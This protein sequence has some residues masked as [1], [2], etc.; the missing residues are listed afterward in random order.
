MRRY[1][2]RCVYV[3]T[4]IALLAP[5]RR[6][7]DRG[8]CAANTP[9][10][11]SH[12]ACARVCVCV[13]GCA[14]APGAAP[15]L[16]RCCSGRCAEAG[17]PRLSIYMLRPSAESTA[18][19]CIDPFNGHCMLACSKFINSWQPSIRELVSITLQ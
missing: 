10:R 8:V 19:G 6:Y 11:R 12:N 17:A 14:D 4:P 16:V 7:A 15:G 5:M 18:Q 9:R 13:R 1:A 2:D 3:D